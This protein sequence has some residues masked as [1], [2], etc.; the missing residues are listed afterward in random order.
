[1]QRKIKIQVDH[2]EK[3]SPTF[4]LLLQTPFEIELCH[5]RWGDYVIND[6]VIIER[7]EAADFLISIIDGRLFRQAKGLKSCP[8]RPVFLLEGDPYGTQI[9][10][11]PRAIQGTL[12]SIQTTWSLPIIH[13]RNPAESVEIFSVI[14]NQQPKFEEAVARPGYRPRRLTTKQLYFLQGLPGIGPAR[15]RQLLECFGSVNRVLQAPVEE[16]AKVP[17]IGGGTAAKI[18]QVLDTEVSFASGS[19]KIHLAI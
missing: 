12:I 3:A 2:R 6:L 11:N 18:R 7:K 19:G 4:G 1:M 15:A 8:G 17:G 5:L 9:Q 14:A 13:S 10:I 16:L